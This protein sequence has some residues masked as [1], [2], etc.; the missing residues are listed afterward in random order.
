MHG[1]LSRDGM[2]PAE[3]LE[4]SREQLREY[5]DVQ[6]LR[7]E[8]TAVERLE[9]AF[10]VTLRDGARHKTRMVLLATG[11]VDEL[12]KVQDIERFYGTTVHVCPYC[13]GWEH[14]DEPLA[15][16]GGDKAA[17]E[18]AIEMLGWSKDVALC[19]DGPPTM[20]AACGERLS[21]LGIRVFE[22]PIA[23][24][25]GADGK[26]AGIRF[27]SGEFLE[28]TG[29]FYYPIQR[30][31]CELGQSLGCK[32]DADG[33]IVASDDAATCVPGLFAAGNTSHG[34]QLV[35]IAA[36]EGTQ[37]AFAVNQALLDADR[38]GEEEAV[39][40]AARP[41]VLGESG[42]ANELVCA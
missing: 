28:R 42:S 3:F 35:I 19:T 39:T 15:V 27:R 1:F 9:K 32:F 12:P 41:V 23:R 14:R 40:R 7:A 13:D 36:A 33:R 8:V 2:S 4:V 10:S 11:L 30:Q 16:H 37:A 25:E 34:L 31:R 18:L 24:L 38:A 6:F 20:D 21:K 26:L 17:A 5:S 29:L 22:E